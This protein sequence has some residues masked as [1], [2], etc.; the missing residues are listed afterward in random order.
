[1][2]EKDYPADRHILLSCL[3]AADLEAAAGL[4]DGRGPFLSALLGGDFTAAVLLGYT[5]P[6][7]REASRELS[8]LEAAQ[9]GGAAGTEVQRRARARAVDNTSGGYFFYQRWLKQALKAAGEPVA[10]EFEEVQLRSL[11]DGARMVEAASQ[12]FTRAQA[13]A[14]QAAFTV[15]LSEGDPVVAFSWAMVAMMNED[16]EVQVITGRGAKVSLPKWFL[17]GD[18]GVRDYAAVFHLYGDQRLPALLGIRQ[19][20]AQR[21]VIITTE[22]YPAEHL[23]RF[24]P[25]ESAFFVIELKDAFDAAEAERQI[26]NFVNKRRLKGQR[27]GFNLTGGTKL[28]FSGA[29]A[30]CERL[31]G[32]PFYFEVYRDRLLYLNDEASAEKV[33]G[34]EDVEDFVEL[35]GREVRGKGKWQARFQLRRGVSEF[36]WSKRSKLSA[37]YHELSEINETEEPFSVERRG[38]KAQL[39]SDH[40]GTIEI[41]GT[42]YRVNDA[43]DFA[44]Y[45]SGKWLEEYSYAQLDRLG[46][47]IKDRRL[48]LEISWGVNEDGSYTAA[49]QEFDLVV[50]NGRRLVVVECKAGRVTN[51]HVYKL[52]SIVRGFGGVEGYGILMSAF[53][54]GKNV[55]RRLEEN[56]RLSCC[57]GRTAPEALAQTIQGL[58]S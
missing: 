34:V 58:L 8:A 57:S 27:L 31:G 45:L 49:S 19:F 53:K 46:K 20:D 15:L 3:S 6:G 23:R 47:I 4:G 1:M 51:D 22:R 50:T 42:A 55:L 30:A 24:L 56:K 37:I 41:D 11:A 39:Y 25:K 18:S 21:Q 44:A 38:V 10:L 33:K 28:M 12:V 48:G 13:A 43:P 17:G 29:R 2:K 36:L 9:A 5:D 35:A 32:V 54:P 40:H 14:P 16:A 52:D 26:Y 7:K